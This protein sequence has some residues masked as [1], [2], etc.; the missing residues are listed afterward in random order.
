TDPFPPGQVFWIPADLPTVWR[1]N[2]RLEFV[3]VHFGASALERIA[4]ATGIGARELARLP[5]R[6]GFHDTFASS[7][8]ATLAEEARRRGGGR[9]GF[10]ELLA[11]TLGVYLA[12]YANRQEG[13]SELA[14][15]FAGDLLEKTL[16]RIEASIAS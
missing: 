9:T 11:Q 8:C 14:E 15:E 16:N 3:A 12:E 7:A 2:G 13:A 6:P 5:F 1:I 10:A 4:S